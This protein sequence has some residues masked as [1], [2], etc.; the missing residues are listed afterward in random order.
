MTDTISAQ[1]AKGASG[2]AGNPEDLAAML[3]ASNGDAFACL[4][5]EDKLDIS[6]QLIALSDDQLAAG[7]L[8]RDGI[9]DFVFGEKA[10]NALR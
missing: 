10:F 3:S 2:L 1:D 6:L 8:T 7:G 5:N 9:L 4:T